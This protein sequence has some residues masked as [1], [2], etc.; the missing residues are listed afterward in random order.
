M[1]LLYAFILE[2]A[3]SAFV[4]TQHSWPQGQSWGPLLNDRLQLVDPSFPRQDGLA[5][6]LFDEGQ[7]SYEDDILWNNFF[8]GV[9]DG[10]FSCYRV[11]LF[12]SYGSPSSC[13]VPHHIGSPLVLREAARI[14]LWPQQGSEGSIGILLNRS[15]FE[16]VVSLFERPLN[17]HPDLLDLIFEWTVGHVG[18]VVEMLRVISY[19]VNLPAKAV[20]VLVDCVS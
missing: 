16:E 6:L 17:L 2:Q 18:A 20:S 15:E 14:S 19:Q 7:D 10:G 12:C 1:N 3:P 8:K 4:N 11:I 13:P 9:V 5:Y